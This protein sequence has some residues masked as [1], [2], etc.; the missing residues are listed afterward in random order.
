MTKGG[1]LFFLNYV[2][3]TQTNVKE[4]VERNVSVSIDLGD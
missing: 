2:E 1:K 3:H 4:L